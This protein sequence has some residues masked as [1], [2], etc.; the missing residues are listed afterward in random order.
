[1][2]APT[3]PPSPTSSE[4]YLRPSTPYS[5]SAVSS[6]D[7]SSSGDSAVLSDLSALTDDEDFELIP[8]NSDSGSSRAGESPSDAEEEAVPPARHRRTSSS[9]ST[10]ALSFPD[11]QSFQH[12]DRYQTPHTHKP[13]NVKPGTCTPERVQGTSPADSTISETPTIVASSRPKEPDVSDSIEDFDHYR[14]SDTILLEPPESKDQPQSKH[15]EQLSQPLETD[16]PADES[17]CSQDSR[18]ENL[19]KPC[20][21]PPMIFS[22]SHHSAATGYR[23]VRRRYQH[24]ARCCAHCYLLLLA[25]LCQS[26]RNCRPSVGDCW[27]DCLWHAF[28]NGISR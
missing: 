19:G 13:A 24:T 15:N 18:V 9:S 27:F 2:P 28:I 4:S 22:R 3:E 25:N 10:L 8:A 14:Y 21:L 23:S 12:V 1:M 20:H 7:D 26:R 17:S 6:A 16:P 5:D 11:P